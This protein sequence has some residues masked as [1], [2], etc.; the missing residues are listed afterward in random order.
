MSDGTRRRR[1]EASLCID[2]AVPVSN[3]L[4]CSNCAEKL[5]KQAANRRAQR[6]AAQLCSECGTVTD[7]APR[8]V[9][10]RDRQADLQRQHYGKKRRQQTCQVCGKETKSAYCAACARPR[11]ARTNAWYYKTRDAGHCVTCGGHR[12]DVTKTR[13]STCT[14]LANSK[15]HD[16]WR[17][18]RQQVLS[19]YGGPVCVGCGETCDP[20]LEIDHINQD[21]AEHRKQI[22]SSALYR[23]LKQNN[24]PDG[25]R[26]L[27]R[28]CNIRAY[29]RIPLPN[30]RDR[31]AQ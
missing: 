30:D 31:T 9:A 27:C 7:G 1:I 3:A 21:G 28:N 26:V 23:W 4:R 24:F 8:C 12:E 20:V 17:R 10:C 5:R 25:F 18:L 16:R 13:C 14:E 29:K 22:G 11:T 6:K 2:C 19:A 15:A